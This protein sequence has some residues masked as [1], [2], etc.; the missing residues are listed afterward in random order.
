M[1]LEQ[2][3]IAALFFINYLYFDRL[4][5]AEIE[6]NCLKRKMREIEENQSNNAVEKD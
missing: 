4:L 6:I 1:N 2:W 5:S 3:L